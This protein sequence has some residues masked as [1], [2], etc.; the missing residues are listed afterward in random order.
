LVA[1]TASQAL[2]ALELS[3][4]ELKR[5]SRAARER[6]LSDHTAER[7]A[8]QLVAALEDAVTVEA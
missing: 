6:V 4:H 5:I 7:R 8:L 2:A 3:D 1:N